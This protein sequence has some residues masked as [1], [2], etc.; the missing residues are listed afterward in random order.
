VFAHEYTH[1][2]S[3]DI[4]DKRNWAEEGLAN[5]AIYLVGYED[6]SLDP[7]DDQFPSHIETYLGFHDQENFGGPEQSLTTWVD[8]G[9]SR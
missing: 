1:L 2:L 7:T 5:Y 6:P 3:N 9:D 8:Q 4:G